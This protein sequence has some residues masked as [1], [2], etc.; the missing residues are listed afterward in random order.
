MSIMHCINRLP[1][2]DEFYHWFI[3][4]QSTWL[5]ITINRCKL[6]NVI[7]WP[8]F[9]IIILIIPHDGK[10]FVST[11]LEKALFNNPMFSL[12]FS[13]NLTDCLYNPSEIFKREW[14]KSLLRTAINDIMCFD[15]NYLRSFRVRLSGASALLAFLWLDVRR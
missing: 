1:V 15:R 8:S 14:M 3:I 11:Y 4:T 7:S 13:I 12:L 2:I 10:P 5:S 9:E 6:K